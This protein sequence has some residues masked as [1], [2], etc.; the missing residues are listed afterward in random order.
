MTG[1]R[2]PPRRG[3]RQQSTGGHAERAP[4]GK[5]ARKTEG[6]PGEAKPAKGAG[7]NIY[8]KPDPSKGDLIP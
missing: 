6:T 3:G 1:K 8:R 5:A 7:Q 4:R 2:V